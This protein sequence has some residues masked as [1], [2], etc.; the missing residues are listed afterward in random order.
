MN[1]HCQ[2]AFEHNSKIP[3]FYDVNR[4]TT[5]LSLNSTPSLMLSF[6]IYPFSFFS[7]TSFYVSHFYLSRS[8]T[9]CYISFFI[10][11]MFTSF[12]SL[13]FPLWICPLLNKQWKLDIFWVATRI[14]QGL[15]KKKS[16]KE[17]MMSWNKKETKQEKAKVYISE[18]EK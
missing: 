9:S 2:L 6:P 16:V 7:C 13:D 3:F 4:L 14:T 5:R 15:E 1:I 18:K 12:F 10:F 8:F 17:R 11:V